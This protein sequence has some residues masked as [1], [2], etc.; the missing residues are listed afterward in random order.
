MENMIKKIKLPINKNSCFKICYDF[1]IGKY[2][3]GDI[4]IEFYFQNKRIFKCLTQIKYFIQLLLNMLNLC[5]KQDKLLECSFSQN[6]LYDYFICLKNDEFDNDNVNSK[7]L[8]DL[9]DNGYVTFLFW[10]EGQTYIEVAEVKFDTV[11]GHYYK[12]DITQ[13]L[14]KEYLIEWTNILTQLEQKIGSKLVK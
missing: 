1:D 11:N 4:Y 5:L 7:T 2:V 3:N 10:R 13:H 9:S 6:L 14:H 8:F 12:V